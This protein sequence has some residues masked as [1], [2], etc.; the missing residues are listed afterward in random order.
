MGNLLFYIVFI[1]CKITIIDNKVGIVLEIDIEK[2]SI[3][4]S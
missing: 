1:V 3:Y 4:F 2:T